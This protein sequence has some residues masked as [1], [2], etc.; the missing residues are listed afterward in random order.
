ML[1]DVSKPTD[2]N[3]AKRKNMDREHIAKASLQAKT[4]KLADLID[5]TRS[6]VEH[7]PKF[8]KVY[9]T[10]KALLLEVLREGDSFLWSMAH[11]I[12]L[13]STKFSEV[14]K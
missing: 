10:E 3:R 1:T 14:Q 2:G 13:N 9:L 7:D 12:L 6:I 8:A 4:I 11:K 5:N